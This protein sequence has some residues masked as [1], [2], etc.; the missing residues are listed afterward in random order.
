MSIYESLQEGKWQYSSKSV[1]V[2]EE[3]KIRFLYGFKNVKS[4]KLG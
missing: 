2:P 4:A 3:M 1:Q